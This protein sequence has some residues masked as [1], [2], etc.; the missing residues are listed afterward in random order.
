M[1]ELTIQRRARRRLVKVQARLEAGTGDRWIPLVI[2]A[3]LALVLSWVSL[4]REGS[5]DTGIDLAG[6]AQG[7]WLLGEGFVPEASLFGDGVHLLELHWSFILYP[8]APLGVV[9]PVSQM[10]VVT[11]SIALG[12]AVFPLWGLARKVANLRIGAATA[13]TVSYALH[14]A[15][16]GLGIDDFHPETLAIPALL[17]VAYFGA[18]KRWFWYWLFVLVVLACRADLGLAVGLWGFV[19]LGDGERRAGLWTLGVGLVW[20][21]GL[22]LVLQPIVGEA[23]VTGGQYGAYGDSLGEVLLNGIRHPFDLLKDL[24]S[25]ANVKL[26]VSLLSPILFLPLLSLRYLLPAVPLG[27]LYLIAESQDTGTF[28]EQNALL[29]AFMFIAA[30]YA[31]N[32]LGNMGV[33]RVFVDKRLLATLAAAAVLSYISASPISIYDKPW[34]WGEVDPVEQAIID[35]AAMLEADVAVRASPSALGPLAERPWLY[36]LETDREPSVQFDAFD[37]RAMLVVDREIP[38]RSPERRA[39]FA[40]RMQ[41][42]GGFELIVDDQENGVSLFYRP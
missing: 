7:V 33:I 40:E 26:L 5:L 32:R 42:L 9:S 4:A 38:E 35:A 37:V 3:T 21:L 18:R 31:L 22:L 10:L 17:A 28:S 25:R 24:G 30:P 13:L 20:A 6:Y 34:E 2:G 12:L 19:L 11:Q 14:P 23:A 1:S 41:N 27:A 29:L 36:P 8:L 39:E 15:T 16:H